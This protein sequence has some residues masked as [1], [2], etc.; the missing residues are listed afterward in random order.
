MTDEEMIAAFLK[1]KGATKVPASAKSD[2]DWK[3]QIKRHHTEGEPVT[4]TP[5]ATGY[6]QS[7]VTDHRGHEWRVN[8]H[9]E[10]IF[11]G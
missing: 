3:H 9:G 10:P 6:T 8:E 5:K 1:T 11:L 7:I 2:I 4:F